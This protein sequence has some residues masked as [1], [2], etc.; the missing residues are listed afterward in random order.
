VFISGY[1]VSLAAVATAALIRLLLWPVLGGS[2]PYM[3]FFPATVF[4]AW[5]A[6]LWPGCLAAVAG[7]TTAFFFILEAP[8]GSRFNTPDGLAFALFVGVNVFMAVLTSSLRESRARAHQGRVALAES[9]ERLRLGAEAAHM[10]AWTRD[11][12]TGVVTWSPE[13][14]RV[15]G[16]RPEEF[17]RTE[18][19]FFDLLHPDDLQRVIDVVRTAVEHRADYE[20]EFRF[21][22]RDGQLRWM[23]ARGRTYCDPDGE[24][25]RLAGIGIDVTD[26]KVA[27]EALRASEARYRSLIAATSSV[28]LTA[29]A[30]AALIEPQPDW[31]EFTGQ[32]WEAHRGWGW[33]DAIHPDDR[34]N[35]QQMWRRALETKSLHESEGRLW[36]AASQQ[37]RYFVARAMPV[38][39]SDGSVREWVGTITDV[40]EKK[41]LDQ[42][43]LH[44]DKLESLGVLAGG[45]AHDFNNLLVGILGNASILEEMAES[46]S[47]TAEFASAIVQA[48]ERAADLTRQML[49]YAG[50]GQ[51]LIRKVDLSREVIELLPL[52]EPA[53]SRSMELRLDLDRALPPVEADPSQVQQIIMNLI[54][55]AAEAT[56]KG[57]V[58]TVSTAVSEDAPLAGFPAVDNA[59]PAER[60]VLL[61]VRDTGHGMDE[62]TQSRIFDPF[63]T[64][65]FT[66]RGLGLAAVLGI[67]RA[68]RGGIRVESEPG[69]GSTFTVYFP[70]AAAQSASVMVSPQ[71]AG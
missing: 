33:L 23:L 38:Q 28:V 52:L 27:E 11:L 24:P 59:G 47:Q 51:F 54:I 69:K 14:A 49:A 20:V 42:K 36:H 62:A 19:S 22:R 31:E 1:L 68:Q 7:G 29:D 60:Y 10:G 66:G 71:S 12:K 18:Q 9:E 37:Y 53:M 16:I 30:T 67:V 2:V 35:V 63:F 32:T 34:D 26:R 70:A 65:K 4:A 39:N 44:A 8:T 58:V 17:G 56:P 6:G 41:R 45:I 43:L 25:A 40:D 3:T 48:S 13:L 15:F 55:N 61:R 21:Y 57:G 46:G 5:F 50:K 64:T